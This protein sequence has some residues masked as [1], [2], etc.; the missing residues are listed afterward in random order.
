MGLTRAFLPYVSKVCLLLT[1][2]PWSGGLPAQSTVRFFDLLCELLFDFP[3]LL[4]VGPLLLL[5]FIF[6]SA[7]FLIALISCH[8][9]L[10][11][12]L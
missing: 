11:F 5:G 3:L 7:H 4:G 9:I 8:V 10:S 6:L 2:S 12:L 1:R